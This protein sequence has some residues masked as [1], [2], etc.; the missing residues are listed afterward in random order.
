VT[1]IILVRHA[2]TFWNDQGKYGGHTDVGLDELGRE[3]IRKVAQRLKKYAVKAV[4]T[5]DLQR[6]YETAWAIAKT[7]NLPV[8]RFCDLREINFG[9]WEGKTYQEIVQE[10]QKIMESWLKDPFN[11]CIPEGETMSEMQKRV[12]RCL[13]EI[14]QKHPEETVVVVTHAGPI[15]TIISYILEVPLQYYWRIKQSNTA[16][17]I[18][19]FY[20][21]Q[22]IIFLLNDISHLEE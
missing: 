13:L 14:V 6:A 4:Y 19:D 15:W 20:Q 10:D 7:H 1:R 8:E 16:V 21:G 3:Q 9:Q 11:T 2:R 12:C 5:S 22:G 17:N 18:I